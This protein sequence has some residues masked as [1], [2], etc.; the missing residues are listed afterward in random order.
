MNP[1]GAAGLLAPA[2]ETQGL[3]R[4]LN[5]W[6]SLLERER[7]DG[8][9]LGDHK[10][11]DRWA[12]AVSRWIIDASLL[13]DAENLH[14][15]LETLRS[16]H[17]RLPAA[18]DT[19]RAE[20]QVT[21]MMETMRAALDRARQAELE[22]TLDPST[23]AAKMLT[24]IYEVP[25]ITSTQLKEDLETGESQVSRSGRALAERG[26]VIKTRHGAE[27]RWR[28]TPR[29]AVAARKLQHRSPAKQPA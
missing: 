28:T 15:G 2:H 11:C 20:A 22:D 21:A 19:A 4:E 17:V 26:L 14:V 16:A 13:G 7:G 8:K 18:G 23:R 1:D 5:E 29:G 6:A 27:R 25:G 24:L 10:V 9:V 12:A 3:R